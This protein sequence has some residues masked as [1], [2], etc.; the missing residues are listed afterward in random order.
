LPH[1]LEKSKE[2][3]KFWDLDQIEE[4]TQQDFMHEKIGLLIRMQNLK[5]FELV[6]QTVQERE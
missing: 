6:F 2:I 5:Q 4:I 3:V 1:D